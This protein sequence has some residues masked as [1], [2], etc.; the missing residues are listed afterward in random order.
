M[1]ELLAVALSAIVA[2]T[3]LL[4]RSERER[5]ELYQRIQ[6]PELAVAAALQEPERSGE[7]LHVPEDDPEAMKLYLESVS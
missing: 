1:I 4:V 5:R 6:A 7:P 2:L 3:Y